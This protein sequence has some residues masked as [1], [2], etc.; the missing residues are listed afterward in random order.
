MGASIG[1]EWDEQQK[2]G[3]C[4]EDTSRQQHPET[5]KGLCNVKQ[6]Q[7]IQDRTGLSSSHPPTHPPHPNFF[8]WKHI[9]DMDRT[10]K[11]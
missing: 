1:G 2:I 3:G 4:I 8:F 9:T 11:S 10:L 6:I 5:E 7:K